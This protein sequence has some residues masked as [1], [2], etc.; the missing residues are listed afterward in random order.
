MIKCQQKKN[1]VKMWLLAGFQ[2]PNFYSTLAPTDDLK[3]ENIIKFYKKKRSAKICYEI[4]KYYGFFG[5]D[6]EFS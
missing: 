2:I 5:S 1:R 6:R 4:N 3:I